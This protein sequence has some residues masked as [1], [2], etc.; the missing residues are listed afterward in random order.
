MPNSMTGFAR[1]DGQAS[2]GD[3][4]CEI[5]SVNHR[6]LEP[7]MRLPE[8]LRALEPLVREQLR[9]KLQR[10][11]IDV[12]FHVSLNKDSPDA[13]SINKD[14]LKTLL[15]AAEQ[16]K[17]LHNDT[18]PIDALRLLQFPG[19][20]QQT[21]V[22]A[23]LVQ[24]LAKNLLEQALES[25]LKHR[26]RE[27]QELH[28]LIDAR[29]DEIA[30]LVVQVREKMPAILAAQKDKLKQ[31][32]D[33]FKTELDGDRLEQEMTIL[34]NKADVAEELDRL[35]THLIEVRHILGESGTIG[36]RLDFMMQELNREANTL[37][38]KSLTSDTTQ[39]A[40]SLKVLIE[41]MREQIQNI[42]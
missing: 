3:V 12:S 38:S 32:L 24:A 39:I 36:R 5:R 18:A 30:L 23:D 29:L 37:S 4:S 2:W 6:Y 31:R 35:D 20:I 34:A 25:L 19:I 10:G 9:Q 41:Q 21:T 16:I 1:T 28:H 15:N 22:D 26:A 14:V 40:V 8:S 27:G 17:Q 11:K 33:E 42:E 7:S 13:L